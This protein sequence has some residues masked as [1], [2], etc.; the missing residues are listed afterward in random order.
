MTGRLYSSAMVDFYH[1]TSEVAADMII[2]SGVI[3]ESSDGGPDAMLG[4]GKVT[5][6]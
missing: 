6:I 5:K 3:M 1:Y 4:S 2:N